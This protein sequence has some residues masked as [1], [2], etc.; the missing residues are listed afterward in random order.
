MPFENIFENLNNSDEQNKLAKLLLEIAYNVILENSTIK[1]DT[2]ISVD[3]S[4]SLAKNIIN[5]FYNTTEYKNSLAKFTYNSNSLI[6]KRIQGYS[7]NKMVVQSKSITPFLNN[8][9][10]EYI[11]SMNEFGLN[12]GFNQPIRKLILQN[13][14]ANKTLSDLKESM[15]KLIIGADNN[16][17][18]F[19]RYATNNIQTA[20]TAYSSIIDQEITNKYSTK[21]KGFM[22]IGTI[23]ETSS[24]QCREHIKLGRRLSLDTIKKEVFPLAD[25]F[26]GTIDDILKLPTL[27]WHIGCRHEFTPLLTD[28]NLN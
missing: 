9:I 8:A 17:G 18:L 20:S 26:Q 25:S 3:N 22:I 14:T 13:I 12:T 27:K 2:I 5:K 11:G 19:Q 24:P 23:I 6:E 16:A 15:K 28:I 7:D 1:N 4:V 21:V 10:N